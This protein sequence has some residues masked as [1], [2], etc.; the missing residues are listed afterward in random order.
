MHMLRQYCSL[1]ML[2]RTCKNMHGGVWLGGL[3]MPNGWHTLC[4]PIYFKAW[5]IKKYS[6]PYMVQIELTY[7]CI[8][9]GIV[10]PYVDGFLNNSG[11]VIGPPFLLFG[12]CPVW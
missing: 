1:S 10:N 6:V 12:S 4:M 3:R 8:K 7:V 9:C 5:G 11:N 2:H